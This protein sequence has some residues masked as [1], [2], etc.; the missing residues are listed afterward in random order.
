MLGPACWCA[1][2]CWCCAGLL[3][4]GEKGRADCAAAGACIGCIGC[5]ACTW[6]IGSNP[7]WLG[8]KAR[9]LDCEDLHCK[10]EW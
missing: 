6:L 9:W 5:A 1:C 10:A 3:K 2:R 8:S 7:R 4:A